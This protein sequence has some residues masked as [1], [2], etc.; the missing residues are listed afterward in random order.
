MTHECSSVPV[1]YI[2][3]TLLRNS[4]QNRSILHHV[5]LSGMPIRSML[6]SASAVLVHELDQVFALATDYLEARMGSRHGRLGTSLRQKLLR[7]E[8]TGGFIDVIQ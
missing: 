3:F 4:Y 6:M 7:I 1:E 5:I 2:Y 8:I